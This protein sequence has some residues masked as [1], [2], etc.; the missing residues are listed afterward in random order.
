MEQVIEM[1]DSEKLPAAVPIKEASSIPEDT[2]DADEALGVALA[3]KDLIVTDEINKS[4]QAKLIFMFNLLSG[5]S[6]PSN[7]WTK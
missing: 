1:S 2:G 6:M 3:S 7:I 4:F 5:L